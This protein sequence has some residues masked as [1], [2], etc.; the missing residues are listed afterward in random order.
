MTNDI[1]A[2]CST[3]NTKKENQQPQNIRHMHTVDI[4]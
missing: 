2:L 4:E 3:T 1:A